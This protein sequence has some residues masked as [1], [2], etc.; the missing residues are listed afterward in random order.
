MTALWLRDK[1]ALE[2]LG[3]HALATPNFWDGWAVFNAYCNH[4]ADK[5][6]SFTTQLRDEPGHIGIIESVAKE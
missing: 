6:G 2:A 3:P 4:L 1:L 5:G